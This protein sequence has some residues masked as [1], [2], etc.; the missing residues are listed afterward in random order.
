ML[1]GSSI[2]RE[3]GRYVVVGVLGYGVQLGTF[4][5]LVH[6]LA[7]PY[8]I[9][10][11]IA[12]LL[13]LVNNFLLNRHWTFEVA[14]GSVSRQATSYGVISAVFFAAQLAVLHALVLTGVPK[15]LAEAVSVVVVVPANFVTQR[16][17]AFRV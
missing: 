15:V 6:A 9:A 12:G 5:V 7:V 2:R 1:G 8:G 14:A 3:A 4:A 11:V 13:A 17:I 16:H 10:A